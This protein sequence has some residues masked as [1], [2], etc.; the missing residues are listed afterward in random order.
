MLKII[1]GGPVWGQKYRAGAALLPQTPLTAFSQHT[2]LPLLQG[3]L[4]FT[5]YWEESSLYG[6]T[7]LSLQVQFFLHILYTLQ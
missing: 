4:G 3:K 6:S 2:F 1:I 5:L 7:I